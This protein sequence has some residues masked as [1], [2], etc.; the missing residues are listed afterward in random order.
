MELILKYII[1]LNIFFILFSIFGTIFV[2]R[3][4]KKERE[5]AKK[6][7]NTAVSPAI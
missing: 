2:L 7:E 1:G 6:E 4:K 3:L 5:E